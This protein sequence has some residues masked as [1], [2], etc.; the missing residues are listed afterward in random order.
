MQLGLTLFQQLMMAL[1]MVEAILKDNHSQILPLK[2]HF[3][4]VIF[5]VFT[6]KLVWVLPIQLHQWQCNPVLLTMTGM[7]IAQVLLLAY[8]WH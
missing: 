8:I 2:V 6:Q 3:H 1:G 4:L 5:L 7:A